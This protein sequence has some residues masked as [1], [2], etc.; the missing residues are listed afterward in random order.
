[1][2]SRSGFALYPNALRLSMES[3]VLV[4]L[5][6]GPIV[7]VA[8]CR[9][10][11]LVD[12]PDRFGFAYGT[13]PGHPES[14]EEAF[15]VDHL[16]GGDVQFTVTA[17]SRPTGLLPRLGGPVTRLVQSRATRAYLRAMERIAGGS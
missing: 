6:V 3:T 5:R 14:G 10:V 13:L 17:F 1:M 9:I 8:P 7:A 12:E 11:Y 16:P 4:L 15:V 2:H